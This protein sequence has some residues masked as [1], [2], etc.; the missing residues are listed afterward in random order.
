M[1]THHHHNDRDN[2][3]YEGIY[4]KDG[5]SISNSQRSN[6]ASWGWTAKPPVHPFHRQYCHRRSRS[7]RHRCHLYNPSIKVGVTE[8]STSK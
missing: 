6:A 5:V 1:L 2:D 7:H 4:S 3:D 8:E